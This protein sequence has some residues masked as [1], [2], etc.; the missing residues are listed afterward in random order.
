MSVHHFGAWRSAQGTGSDKCNSC[1]DKIRKGQPTYEAGGLDMR[2]HQ[3]CLDRTSA[4]K[5]SRELDGVL[6]FSD[7]EVYGIS[8]GEESP[9]AARPVRRLKQRN[10]SEDF[11]NQVEGQPQGI[12]ARHKGKIMAGAVLLAGVAILGTA[13]LRSS[14]EE[15]HRYCLQSLEKGADLWCCAKQVTADAASCLYERFEAANFW[16]PAGDLDRLPLAELPKCADVPFV[17]DTWTVTAAQKLFHRI[18]G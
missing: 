13:V 9:R 2:V 7:A 17:H 10:K 8:T 6:G 1:H 3:A 11:S 14:G 16:T 18:F 15:W 12:W 4:A 5:E